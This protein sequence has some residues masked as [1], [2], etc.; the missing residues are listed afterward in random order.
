MSS[1]IVK[2]ALNRVE[3]DLDFQLEI[4]DGKVVDARC[5]GTLYRGFEQILFEPQAD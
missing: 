2:I 1:R 3:G 4:E 5:I